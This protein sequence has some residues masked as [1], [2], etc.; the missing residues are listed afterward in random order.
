[1]LRNDQADAR[2]DQGLL[3]VEDVK[4]RALS[5]LGFVANAFQR[6]LGCII[7][8]V[9]GFDLRLRRLQLAPGL[10]DIRAGLVAHLIHIQPLLT[11][12]LLIEANRRVFRAALID[13]NRQ[14][15]HR[16]SEKQVRRQ[17]IG[18]GLLLDAALKGERRP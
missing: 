1:M 17:N 13:R 9:C 6:P 11:D 16:R 5:G 3:G 18:I 2:V 14:I 15:E 8:P 4:R 10:N 12:V 7:L